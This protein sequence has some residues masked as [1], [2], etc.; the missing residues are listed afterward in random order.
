M[1]KPVGDARGDHAGR[2]MHRKHARVVG[3]LSE[4][5][6]EVATVVDRRPQVAHVLREH[7]IETIEQVGATDFDRQLALLGLA[8]LVAHLAIEGIPRGGHVRRQRQPH[9]DLVRFRRQPWKTGRDVSQL[10]VRQAALRRQCSRTVEQRLRHTVIRRQD[11]TVVDKRQGHGEAT[12]DGR[13]EQ[14]ER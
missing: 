14:H 8:H 4:Y 12:E 2:V 9:R 7:P 5:F 10:D 3:E 11:A 6:L 13:A 1:A